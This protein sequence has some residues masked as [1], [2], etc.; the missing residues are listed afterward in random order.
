VRRILDGWRRGQ[1]RV[2]GR[3]ADTNCCRVTGG[4]AAGAENGSGSTGGVVAAP[5][6]IAGGKGGAADRAGARIAGLGIAGGMASLAWLA[7]SVAST[8]GGVSTART[9]PPSS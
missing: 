9:A 3:L 2:R 8:V 7:R 4:T 1:D 5:G 6:A